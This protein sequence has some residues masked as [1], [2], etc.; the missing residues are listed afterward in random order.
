VFRFGSACRSR[1][2]PMATSPPVRARPTTAPTL[3]AHRHRRAPA[4]AFRAAAL[5]PASSP[6]RPTSASA[7][8]SPAAAGSGSACAHSRRNHA[9]GRTA[10]SPAEASHSAAELRGAGWEAPLTTKRRVSAP[11]AGAPMEVPPVSLQHGLP[12]VPMRPKP[13]RASHGDNP[14][15]DCMAA[16]TLSQ[17]PAPPPPAGSPAR[18]RNPARGSVSG[19]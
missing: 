18:R 11:V 15:L 12:R 13:L 10:S 17:K 14:R 8:S 4:A 5:A 7:A 2:G 16:T 6:G 9:A 19:S 1:T 3:T